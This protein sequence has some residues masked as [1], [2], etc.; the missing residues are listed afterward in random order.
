MV[1]RKMKKGGRTWELVE[2]AMVMVAARFAVALEKTSRDLFHAIVR[3][4]MEKENALYVTAP[5]GTST[6]GRYPDFLRFLPTAPRP[7]F[8]QVVMSK[9]SHEQ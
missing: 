5:E 3:D 9:M 6:V 8:H 2:V 1:I 7:V 4:V